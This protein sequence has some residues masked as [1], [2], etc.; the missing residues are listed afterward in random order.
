MSSKL[1]EVLFLAMLCCECDSL[2]CMPYL[3][4]VTGV[5][6]ECSEMFR[7]PAAKTNYAPIEYKAL[8]LPQ[9]TLYRRSALIL[10]DM[11]KK[12]CY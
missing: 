5:L 9:N 8:F 4:S 10:E 1:L 2:E 7:G 11:C 12:I 3:K 6:E